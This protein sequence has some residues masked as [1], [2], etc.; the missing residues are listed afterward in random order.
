MKVR[1][2][3]KLLYGVGINDA[4]YRLTLVVGGKT[5]MC[6][7]YRVWCNML[8][9]CYYKKYHERRP[10]YVGCSV[11]DDWLHFSN[12]KRW[13]EQQDWQ[14]KQLDKDILVEDNKVYSPNTCVFVTSSLNLFL[15]DSRRTR[16]DYPLGVYYHKKRGKFASRCGNP[17][18]QKTEHLG[19]FDCPL[20]AHRMW[21]R[22]KHEIACILAEVQSDHRVA[23]ALREK[24]SPTKDWSNK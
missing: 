17:I 22:R 15:V 9:R 4:D 12:F 19:Y 5:E 11:C 8:G 16:G 23:K 13:M 18:D 20:K 1:R 2:K 21:Q 7:F 10:T 6:P 14:G 24:Y 3:T